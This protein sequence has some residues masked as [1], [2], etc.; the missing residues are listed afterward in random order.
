VASVKIL[1]QLVFVVMVVGAAYLFAPAGIGG[2]ITYAATAGSSMAPNFKTGD[3]AVLRK[4]GPVHVGDIAGYRSGLTGQLVVHRV[5]AENNGHLTFKGDNNWWVDTYQPTQQEVLGKLWIHLGGAGKKVNAIQPS[6]VLGGIGL[7]S[8]MTVASTGG[9]T[10]VR[11]RA[12]KPSAPAGAFGSQG[13]Q[14]LLAVLVLIGVVSSVL[15]FVAFRSNLTTATSKTVLAEQTG[16]FSYEGD[17]LPGPVY[18]GNRVKTG[19]PIYV[20]LVPSLTTSFVY[21]LNAPTAQDVHG[22]VRLYAVTRGINGWERRTDLVP[23]TPFDGPDATVRA[24]VALAGLMLLATALQDATGIS[25][26]YW[27][28]AISAEVILNGT[29]EGQPFHATF[30]PF[31]TLRVTPPNEIY[32]ETAITRDFESAPPSAA[33]NS[34]TSGFAPHA[35]LSVS[36]PATVPATL[37]L[38]FTN[39]RVDQVRRVST[40]VAIASFLL[41][42]V[43]GVLMARSLRTPAARF[44]ARYGNRLVRVAEMSAPATSVRMETMEDLVRVADRYQSVI[45]W[46]HHEDEDIY[47][48]Q[49]VSSTFI[50][51]PVP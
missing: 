40:I 25:P 2:R 30:E 42:V 27:T 16:D 33:I 47:A 8:I 39:V 35:D 15:A 32:V 22:T 28:T 23:A 12:R 36:L 26:H 17:S 45:L 5:I 43:V 3:L 49:D 13:A 6:W 37:G 46:I 4:S 48:V 9:K 19:D 10:A 24:D 18:E 14:I 51:R 7:V 38:V 44:Y 29:M 50:F 34:S 1:V 21:H 31:Y 41:A 11:G 20:N